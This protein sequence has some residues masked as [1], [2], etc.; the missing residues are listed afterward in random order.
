MR[1]YAY[2]LLMAATLLVTNACN[3]SE[4][5]YDDRQ[6]RENVTID[7][8]IDIDVKF[9]KVIEATPRN[10]AIDSL[11]S[12]STLFMDSLVLA[13]Y[14]VSANV[15]ENVKSRMLS[16]YN[17]RNYQYAWFSQDGPTE[18]GRGFW[19]MYSYY[20]RNENG[21]FD[22][23]SILT[24]I[25]NK[26]LT[27]TS[28]VYNTA[29]TEVMRAE[30]QLSRHFIT[31]ALKYYGDRFTDGKELQHFI[32][33][34]KMDANALA[35]RYIS[36]TARTTINRAYAALIGHLE[37]Y[38]AIQL[39]GGWPRVE[40]VPKDTITGKSADYI[41]LL[42]QRLIASGELQAGDTSNVYTDE[43]KQAIKKFQRLHGYK[44]TGLISAAQL[45]K[46]N[47]PVDERIEQIVINLDRAKWFIDHNKGRIIT[48]NIPEFVL[49]STIGDSI[50]MAQNVVVGKEGTNTTMFTGKLNQVVFSPYWNIPYGITKN[51]ILPGINRGGNAYLARQ[52]MEIVGR[53]GDGV[54]RVRQRPGNKNSLGRVKFLFPNS[55]DIYFH[56]TP[57]KSLFSRDNRAFSH[58]CIRLSRP[59]EL[60]K[61]LLQRDSS[62]TN[63]KLDSAMNLKKEWKVNL[64]W[65]VPVIISYYTA[66][67][68]QEGDLH[69][70]ED[71]Y[72]HDK[73]MAQKMFEPNVFTTDS[74]GL[75]KQELDSVST[76]KT[77]DTTRSGK[78]LPIPVAPEKPVEDTLIPEAVLPVTE[79]EDSV[80]N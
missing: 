48:V 70:A 45:K 41:H 7:S 34:Q 37:K 67:V 55:F 42:K 52:D 3:Q 2:L 44:E 57:G 6:P 17:S 5:R 51:E 24:Q 32:P 18:Q 50:E 73:M 54:P 78:Q 72:G 49:R 23:D 14:F 13:D 80:V 56:D 53:W 20:L 21:K 60:A 69:F 4:I 38:K 61:I 40:R 79:Q 11:N 12:Y 22:K 26:L 68:D 1:K 36:D 65:P 76:P 25:M 77:R 39:S 47:V 29:N 9:D 31:Y 74:A 19:N 30:L 27:D 33:A 71:I 66:W 16:F 46:M 10:Y 59:K 8:V 28:I 75:S 15:P 58:G 64:P 63:K 35:D 62:W 43:L